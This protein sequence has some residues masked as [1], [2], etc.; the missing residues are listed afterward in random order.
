MANKY[1][2]LKFKG[3]RP[4]QEVEA[5]IGDC[6][7]QV[8]RIHEEGGITQVYFA[9]KKSVAPRAAKAM[10][11]ATEAEAVGDRQLKRIG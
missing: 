9:A 2:R 11:G 3:Q 10:K 7:G 6:G 8:L 5:I 1:W 4:S